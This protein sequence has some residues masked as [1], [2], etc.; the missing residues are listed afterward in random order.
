M[1]V[2]GLVTA[3]VGR[4]GPLAQALEDA[5]ADALSVGEVQ[6]DPFL[7]LLRAAQATEHLR[8]YTGVAVAFARTPMTVAYLANDLQVLSGGRF[9]LGLGSQVRA[10]VTLSC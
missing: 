9:T 10:S 2:D 6:H 8:L 1:K 4:L 5:G 3:D 7:V